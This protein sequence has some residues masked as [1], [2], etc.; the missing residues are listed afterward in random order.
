MYYHAANEKF[1]IVSILN[2]YGF[3]TIN[4]EVYLII[5]LGV[6]EPYPTLFCMVG[7][8]G[9]LVFLAAK[10]ALHLQKISD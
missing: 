7:K 10:Q 6:G 8:E 3:V 5:C 4:T 9:W 2:K 1:G